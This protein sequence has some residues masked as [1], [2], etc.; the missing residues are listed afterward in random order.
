NADAPALAGAP[1]EQLVHQYNAAVKLVGRM[2]RRYPY[3]MV[4]EFMYVPRLTAEQCKDQAAVDAWTKVL[5]EQL[6]AKESGASQ[7]SYQVEH[8][9]EQ[10]VY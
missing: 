2:S 4:Q 7:Y 9:V 5:V 10:N 3:A 6:N 8:N 1:L